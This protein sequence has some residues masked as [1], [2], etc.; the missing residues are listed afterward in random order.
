MMKIMLSAIAILMVSAR[1]TESSVKQEKQITISGQRYQDKVRV[2]LKEEEQKYNE[3]A[4]WY[5]NQDIDAIDKQI[6]S[7]LQS[8]Q[9]GSTPR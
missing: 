3:G 8:E 1:A 7:E 6:T 5:L 2:A 4:L 9:F